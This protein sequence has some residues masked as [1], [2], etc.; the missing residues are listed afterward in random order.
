MSRSHRHVTSWCRSQLLDGR[1]GDAV[2]YP[3]DPDEPTS[4]LYRLM[5]ARRRTGELPEA[6]DAASGTGR[7]DDDPVVVISP[8]MPRWRQLAARARPASRRALAWAWSLATLTL[9]GVLALAVYAAVSG[10]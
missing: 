8:H 9:A 6:L 4:T 7:P 5:P 3:P 2:W 1:Y 10:R